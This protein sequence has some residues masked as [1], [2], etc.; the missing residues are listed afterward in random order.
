MLAGHADIAFVRFPLTSVELSAIPLWTESTVV[1]ASKE[2][3]LTVVDNLALTDLADEVILIPQ[4]NVLS[5]SALPGLPF[6]G[7]A[8]EST[9]DAVELAAAQAGIVIV[10]RTPSRSAKEVLPLGASTYHLS[11]SKPLRTRL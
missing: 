10:P 3:N 9:L 2:S 1:I 7:R 4:D 8:P 11:P 5:W 6:M